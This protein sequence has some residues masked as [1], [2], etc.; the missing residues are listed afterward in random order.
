MR[1]RVP[2]SP[3]LL[4][5]VGSCPLEPD[6]VAELALATVPGVAREE[7]SRRKTGERP[8]AASASGETPEDLF[9]VVELPADPGDVVVLQ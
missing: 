4:V 2:P 8:A 7:S 6:D 5:H 3:R 1:L 9:V